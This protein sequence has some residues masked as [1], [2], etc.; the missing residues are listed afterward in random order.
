MIR[1]SF[2]ASPQPAAHSI[3]RSSIMLIQHSLL[4][5]S[6]A[7]V[8]TTADLVPRNLGGVQNQSHD[9]FFVVLEFFSTDMFIRQV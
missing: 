9:P 1:F 7:S 6:D 8:L 2:V 4:K 3:L 5:R